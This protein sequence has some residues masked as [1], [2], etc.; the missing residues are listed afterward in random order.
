VVEDGVMIGHDYNHAQFPGV[1]QAV[2]EVFG[3]GPWLK[4]FGGAGG[5]WV[6]NVALWKSRTAGGTRKPQ[7]TQHVSGRRIKAGS[8][9]VQQMGIE[10]PQE[11]I[12]GL[13][14]L[15]NSLRQ[16]A[17]EPLRIVEVGSWV[18]TTAI[19]MADAA[20]PDGR[21]FCID[22][23]EGI[24]GDKTAEV[25]EQVGASKVYQQFLD[26][27]GDWFG[28]RI[29]ARHGSSLEWAQRLPPQE[30]HLVFL[31][32]DHSEQAVRD[33]I[34]AWMRHLRPDGILAGHDFYCEDNPGV[35]YAVEGIFGEDIVRR[36]GKTVW[37]VR[38]EDFRRKVGLDQPQLEEA[39]A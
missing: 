17:R 39:T 12:D 9:V 4:D 27:V 21:V 32:G 37:Y 18:G 2:H 38:M 13:G 31:D 19:S 36:V 15:V 29:F 14:R 22:H 28:Q 3:E 1:A 16:E 11:D 20:G 34:Q 23:W 35:T 10:T 6:V 8:R 26:N 7:P 30:L 5:F 24:P 33:D 25:V